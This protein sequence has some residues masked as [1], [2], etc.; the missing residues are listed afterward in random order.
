MRNALVI[1]VPFLLLTTLASAQV[2][3]PL[4]DFWL[5]SYWCEYPGT[6]TV[7]LYVVPDGSGS[8]FYEARLPDGSQVDA[9]IHVTLVDGAG[10]P[11][12]F[13]PYEDIWLD[14][15][16]THLALCAGG[17]TADGNT[18]FFGHTSWFNPVQA[19]GYS[20]DPTQVIVNGM[21]LICCAGVNLHFNSPDLNGDLSV[22]LADVGLFAGDFYGVYRFRSD[23]AY[24]GTINLSDVSRLA[25]AVGRSCP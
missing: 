6:E 25:L 15:Q 5:S 17:S 3:G 11:I 10:V 21:A 16:D 1:T 23:L 4:P 2:V 22:N 12:Q 18:D 20:Q 7:G 8:T 9:R 24:D 13:Y 14:S 19:G